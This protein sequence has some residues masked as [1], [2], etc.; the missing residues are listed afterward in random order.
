MRDWVCIP[1]FTKANMD[2]LAT[3]VEYIECQAGHW[4]QLQCGDQFN[5]AMDQWL[6]KLSI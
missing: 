6:K 4:V 1:A 2:K 5:A 3:D